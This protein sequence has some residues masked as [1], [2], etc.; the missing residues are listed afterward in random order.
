MAPAGR[1]ARL[2]IIPLLNNSVLLPGVTI[3]I[4]LSSRPDIPILLTYLF[5]RANSRTNAAPAFVGC[6][7]VSS[8]NLN[9][10][11]QYLLGNGEH[12][13]VID[14]SIYQ[15][16]PRK[17]RLFT[18]GSVARVIG[19]QGRPNSEPYLLVEGTRRFAIRKFTKDTPYYEAD[20]SVFE[21]PGMLYI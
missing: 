1:P 7:P 17:D 3:R 16:I 15:D 14:D 11:G 8:P 9:R 2:P 20:V 12:G 18:F 21:D 13:H 4:P 6:V 19:V 5:S 10:D